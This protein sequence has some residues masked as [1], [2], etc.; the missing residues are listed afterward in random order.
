MATC[1]IKKKTRNSI[2]CDPTV[3]WDNVKIL[4]D[5]LLYISKSDFFFAVFNPSFNSILS[6]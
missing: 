3:A 6:L 2:F 4:T 1:G 5:D